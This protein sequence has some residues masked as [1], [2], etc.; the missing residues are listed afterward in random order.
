MAN[1]SSGKV[2]ALVWTFLLTEEA[3]YDEKK[4]HNIKRLACDLFIPEIHVIITCTL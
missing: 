1:G 2:K 3:T 4:K